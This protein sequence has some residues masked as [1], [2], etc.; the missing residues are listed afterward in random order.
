M[1]DENASNSVVQSQKRDLAWSVA[2]ANWFL[3]GMLATFTTSLSGGTGGLSEF[4]GRLLGIFLFGAVPVA[5][6][7]ILTPNKRR[8]RVRWWI[9]IAGWIVAL[10]GLYG[11][12]PRQ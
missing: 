7:Y 1:H 6:A 10:L 8:F 3:L 2:G 5:G 11:A 9:T 12:I 4:V